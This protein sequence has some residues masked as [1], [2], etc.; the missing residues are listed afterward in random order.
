MDAQRA[1]TEANNYKDLMDAMKV[2]HERIEALSRR[3]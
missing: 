1:K 3:D 2:S